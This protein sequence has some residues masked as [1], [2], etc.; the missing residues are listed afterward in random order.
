MKHVDGHKL[1]V[2]PKEDAGTT[3]NFEVTVVDTGLV[4]HSKKNN[5]S[6]GQNKAESDRERVAILNQIQVLIDMKEENE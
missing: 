6:R 1:E 2:I 3:G 5:S 4:L